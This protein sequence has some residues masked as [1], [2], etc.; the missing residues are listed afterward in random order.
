MDY[1]PVKLGDVLDGSLSET[2]LSNIITVASDKTHILQTTSFDIPVNTLINEEF[3]A[4]RIAR[5]GRVGNTLDTVAASVYLFDM[6][7]TGILWN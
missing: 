3:L 5:D 6:E 2:T 1:A 7:V 4:F